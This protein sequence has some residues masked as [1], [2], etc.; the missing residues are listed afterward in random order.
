[1]RFLAFT[2]IVLGWLVYSIVSA[3]AG[4][5]ICLSVNAPASAEAVSIH[6]HDR[7]HAGM[8]EVAKKADPAKAPCSTDGAAHMSYCGACL[9]VLPPLMIDTGAKHLSA[10]PAPA[11]VQALHD[12]RPTPQ[13]PPPRLPV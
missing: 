2:S 3:W 8:M 7:D 5:P 6:H 4:C 11:V 1:M 13:A 9:V 10:Y 12:N